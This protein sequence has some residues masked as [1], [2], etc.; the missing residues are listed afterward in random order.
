MMNEES[1]IK[2]PKKILNFD[3]SKPIAKS[4][5]TT[6][7][8]AIIKRSSGVKSPLPHNLEYEQSILAACILGDA[9]RA[10]ELLKADDFYRTGHQKLFTTI[11][12]LAK[13]GI[14]VDLPSLVTALRDAGH[15]KEV[16]GASYVASL[17][18]QIPIATNLE[19]FA[20]ELRTKHALRKIIETANRIQKSCYS[21]NGDAAAVIAA[22]KQEIL[23][24]EIEG[25]GQSGFQFIHN[26]DILS[27][28]QPIEWR[29]QEIL[30]EN[31]LYYDFGDPGSFKT[32]VAL[33]RLLCI[34]AGIDYH[35][36][37]VEQGIVFYIAGEGQ[38]GI[39]RRIAAWHAEHKTKAKDIPFFMAKTPTQLMDS[40][41]LDSVKRAVD[42][43]S[44]KYGCP[45][46]VHI[47]TLARNFGSGDEN[48]TADMNRVIQNMD[49][50]FGNDFCRGITHHTG[51]TN[52]DRARGSIALHG[53]ADAAFRVSITEGQ[54][55]LVECTKQKDAPKALP[56]LFNLETVPLAIGEQRIPD[57][58]YVLE[59]A[60]EGDEAT[61]AAKL[62]P[63]KT[64]KTS[65]EMKKALKVLDSMYVEYEKTLE[66]GGRKG[67]IP[68]VSILDWRETCLKKKLFQRNSNFYRSLERMAERNLIYLDE[69]KI[70]VYS[71]SMYLKYIE[72]ECDFYT[73]RSQTE[74]NGVEPE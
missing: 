52:K 55:V 27:N 17:V 68:R 12:E 29:I 62:P 9:N 18:D 67:E 40:C 13:S 57:K 37:K 36:H 31:S 16:G 74:Q 64:A 72:K 51:H 5:S 8:S 70:Y 59:L 48:S 54:Q 25:T 43:L 50:A 73:N 33:D 65:P 26:A 58:S 2:K 49:T 1:T 7:L 61:A 45:A 20:G 3:F 23:E 19:H 32:F 4:H 69:N 42:E 60:A 35:G 41:A 66:A 10:A 38:Q 47:D 30:V 14:A 6:T 63:A 21:G 22:A 46:V 56:M 11:C 15:L 44:S 34:A 71:V 28:L 24:I 39:G 53:A